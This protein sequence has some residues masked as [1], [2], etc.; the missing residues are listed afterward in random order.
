M[1]VARGRI[2]GEDALLTYVLFISDSSSFEWN[3]PPYDV[4]NLMAKPGMPCNNYRGY[5][6]VFKKCREVVLI[7]INPSN[8]NRGQPLGLLQC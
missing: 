3:L 8:L 7:D 2:S 1:A 6:D 5:C 4:P